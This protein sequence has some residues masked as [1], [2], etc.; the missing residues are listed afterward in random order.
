MD[1][2]PGLLIDLPGPGLRLLPEAFAFLLSRLQSLFS[3]FSGPAQGLSTFFPGRV[4]GLPGFIY[5]FPGRITNGLHGLINLLADLMP[6]IL[7]LLFGRYR[8]GKSGNKKNTTEYGEY[9]SFTY[10]SDVVLPES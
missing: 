6:G 1:F 2:F 4:Y 7:M 9:F 10:H 5:R 8:T 3:F